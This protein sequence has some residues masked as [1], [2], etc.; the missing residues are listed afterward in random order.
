MTKGIAEW[1]GS[2]RITKIPIYSHL[3]Q[4][5]FNCLSSQKKKIHNFLKTDSIYSITM[6]IM[7][8]TDVCQNIRSTLWPQVP[9]PTGGNKK[10]KYLQ[11]EGKDKHKHHIMWWTNKNDQLKML[12]DYDT[13]LRLV[14]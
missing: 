7:L 4:F 11:M 1:L 8:S 6:Q 5:E 14:K 13:C 12:A 2:L 10:T 3:K 9:S